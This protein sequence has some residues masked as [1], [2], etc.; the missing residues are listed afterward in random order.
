M[1]ALWMG[2]CAPPMMLAS[3]GFQAL[4]NGTAVYVNGELEVAYRIPFDTVWTAT[5]NAFREM[6]FQ[7]TDARIRTP[8]KALL[9]AEEE[10]GRSTSVA[11]TLRTPMVTKVTIRVGFVG[12]QS[13]SRLMM[14][15]I[16]AHM[17]AIEEKRASEAAAR[18]PA[19]AEGATRTVP[20]AN[21]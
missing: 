2:G 6:E 18:P 4:S 11:V 19:E 8:T 1:T 21:P 14:D 17:V 7:I 5:Q 10:S 9:F 16:E 3:A 15:R 13:L 12:D 20:A